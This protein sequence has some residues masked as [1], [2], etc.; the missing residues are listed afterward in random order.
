LE[1]PRDAAGS[2]V[3]VVARYRFV[4]AVKPLLGIRLSPRR[5]K[6][7]FSRIPGGPSFS[8]ELFDGRD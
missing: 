1:N 6:P 8:G 3:P 4:K 7:R 2:G 5:T